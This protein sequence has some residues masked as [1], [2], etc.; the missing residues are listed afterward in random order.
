MKIEPHT[1]AVCLQNLIKNLLQGVGYYK[2]LDTMDVFIKYLELGFDLLI[3]IFFYVKW[4]Q[5][6]QG[7]LRP[8]VKV[9]PK[10]FVIVDSKR[11]WTNQSYTYV[12]LEKCDQ[13]CVPI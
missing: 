1:I 9:A 10:G 6:M 12:F 5:F 11:L 13:F 7:G 3:Y 2:N 4:F 8:S